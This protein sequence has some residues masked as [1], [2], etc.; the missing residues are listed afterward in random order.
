M[1]KKTKTA[2]PT[3]TL[4]DVDKPT[5]VTVGEHL[6]DPKDVSGIKKIRTKDDLYVIVLKSQPDMEYPMWANGEEVAELLKHFNVV[7]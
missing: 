6:I 1:A 3:V 7:G 5:L 4:F 2:R